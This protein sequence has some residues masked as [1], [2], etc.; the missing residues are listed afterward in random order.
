MD[1]NKQ[2]QRVPKNFNKSFV[3]RDR[4]LNSKGE[5]ICKALGLPIR[6]SRR[7]I[8]RHEM[9]NM[10]L[11]IESNIA[12]TGMRV[13]PHESLLLFAFQENLRGRSD[14]LRVILGLPQRLEDKSNLLN[15][16]NIKELL[17]GC[18]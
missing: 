14:Q 17:N 6:D 1:K 4:A 2:L 9:L 15:K 3:L 16:S 11:E 12:L 8:P 7:Y 13:S 5:K 18:K 10:L